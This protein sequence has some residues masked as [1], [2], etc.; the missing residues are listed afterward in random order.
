[1]K[2]KGYRENVQIFLQK[3]CFWAYLG[4]LWFREEERTA[5]EKK[6]NVQLIDDDYDYTKGTG[7]HP[8]KNCPY[9]VDLET[10]YK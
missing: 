3:G 4:W 10:V 2:L 8:D 9:D 5:Y 7:V 6:M 1:M